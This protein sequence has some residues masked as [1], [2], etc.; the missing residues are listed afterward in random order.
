MN[1]QTKPKL[2]G[3]AFVRRV[4]NHFV[5]SQRRFASRMQDMQQAAQARNARACCGSHRRRQYL[6]ECHISQRVK[7]ASARCSNLTGNKCDLLDIADRIQQWPMCRSLE[8][9]RLADRLPDSRQI[10][11]VQISR[12]KCCM[13]EAVQ[14]Q[15]A[16]CLQLT[17][18]GAQQCSARIH[19]RTKRMHELVSHNLTRLLYFFTAAIGH[20]NQ[21]QQPASDRCGLS[22]S[23]CLLLG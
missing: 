2:T 11:H 22:D 19:W 10:L 4:C 16:A 5:I 21:G 7:V 9:Q 20:S 12:R 23:H 6:A 3:I 13:Q 17:G 18:K 8:Q 14:L 15:Q 1:D